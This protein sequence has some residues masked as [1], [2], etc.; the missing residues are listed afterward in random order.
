MGS[1]EIE[2][3]WRRESAGAAPD[4]TCIN[5]VDG[6]VEVDGY[7]GEAMPTSMLCPRTQYKVS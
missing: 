1:G 4:L 6:M 5:P 3:G 2:E 7:Y